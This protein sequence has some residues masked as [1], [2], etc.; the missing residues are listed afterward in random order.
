[1][2]ETLIELSIWVSTFTW[3]QVLE[4]FYTVEDTLQGSWM[5]Q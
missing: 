3:T 1:M 2:G 4:G 5:F